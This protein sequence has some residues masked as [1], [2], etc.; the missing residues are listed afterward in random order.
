MLRVSFLVCL[1]SLGCA[2]HQATNLPDR[3]PA[4]GASDWPAFLGPTADSV[5]PER[6]IIRPWPKEGLRIVWQKRLGTGY[7]MPSI[8]EGRLFQFDRH[9]TQARLSCL[10]SDTGEFLWKFEYRTDYDDQFGYDEQPGRPCA[11]PAL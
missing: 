6:G 1:I 7:G 4:E 3:P 11:R 8:S 5:S 2:R 9:G 10:K